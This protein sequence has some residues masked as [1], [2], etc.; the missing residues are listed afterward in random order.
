[1]KVDVDLTLA[2]AGAHEP[3]VVFHAHLAAVQKVGY[4][5]HSLFSVLRAGTNGKDQIAE[6][7]FLTG[8]EYLFR[9][10]HMNRDSLEQ[11]WCHFVQSIP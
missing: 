6:R 8:F 2:N 7:E 5:R 3:T 1:L 11:M 9:F 4:G 10:L